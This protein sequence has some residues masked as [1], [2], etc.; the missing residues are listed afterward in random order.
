MYIYSPMYVEVSI[1]GMWRAFGFEEYEDWNFFP[2]VLSDTCNHNVSIDTVENNQHSAIC[3]LVNLF[4]LPNTSLT[5][6][7][8]C[9][10]S[11]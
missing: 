2:E 10:S 3:L 6:V 8:S 4:I 9:I 5:G 11:V 1:A 7:G